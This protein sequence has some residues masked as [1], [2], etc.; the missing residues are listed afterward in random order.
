MPLPD[1][2]Q[3]PNATFIA[4][5]LASV[6]ALASVF[7]FQFGFGLIPCELCLWQRLPHALAILIAGFGAGQA[8]AAS[9]MPNPL[10]V[11]PWRTFAVVAALL[12]LDHAAG[13]ATAAFHVGVE[14]H[15]WAGTDACTGAAP[16]G[17]SVDELR[18]RLLDTPPARCDQIAWS[19]LGISLAGFNL[20][21]SVA[22]AAAAATSAARF[23]ALAA[24]R[25]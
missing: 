19:F 18:A 23:R 2:A 3:N 11:M 8:R 15:W 14:Q 24:K 22:L 12:A 6:A 21:L 20:I 7:V 17:L 5:L 10:R 4:F 16:A 9:H 25:P 1:P 13:A